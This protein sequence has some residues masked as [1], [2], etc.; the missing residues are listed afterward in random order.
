[1]TFFL[2]DERE[3]VRFPG[4]KKQDLEQG[5]DGFVL[6]KEEKNVGKTNEL[7]PRDLNTDYASGRECTQLGVL[8]GLR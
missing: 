3:T 5:G 7:L 6:I 2:R 4:R 1:M 8:A